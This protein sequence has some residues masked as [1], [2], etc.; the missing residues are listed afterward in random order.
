M[1][2]K[3]VF[4][5][6]GFRFCEFTDREEAVRFLC[7]ECNGKTVSFGGSITLQELDLY[8]RLSEN[9]SC[10]WHWK[11]D[12]ADAI[13][14]AEVF[15]TSANAI[16]ETGEIVNIDGNCNRVSSSIYGHKHVYFVIGEN[17]LCRDL[18]TAWERARNIAAPLNAKRLN[19]NTPCAIDGKCHDCQS[20]DCICAVIS[21][22]RRKPS[23]CGATVVFI[24][25]T[26][27]Y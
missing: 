27:G 23:S 16:S 22:L 25:E 8:N 13:R 15:V 14:N 1:G 20:Q 26:L 10:A 7:E 9:S 12:P 11:K 2:L 5:K 18:P 4:E 17:K 3:D 24:H 21:V 6:R 19:K